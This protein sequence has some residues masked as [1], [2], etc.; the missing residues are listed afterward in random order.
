MRPILFFALAI[1]V[2]L[3]ACGLEQL[4]TGTG[5][6]SGDGGAADGGD[7]GA[8]AGIQGAGCGIERQ[9]GITLCAAT[10]MCPNLVID[11]QAFPSCG[12]RIRGGSVDL[13]CGCGEQI[14]PMGVFA[15][16]AQA[17]QL[18]TSQTEQQVCAQ[19]GDGRCTD[20][21]GSGGSSTSSSSGGSS[22]GGIGCDKQCMQEC[23]GG[24]GCASV[25]NCQ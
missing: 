2:G 12:F 10:S 25:C 8:D 24:A 4:N 22:S 16:C 6:R 1:A 14:C 7:G 5:T 9:T 19:L 23:G 11:T 21:T 15:T 20:A 3:S 18:L 13:V 17:Q